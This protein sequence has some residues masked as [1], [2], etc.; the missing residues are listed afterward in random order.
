MGGQMGGWRGEWKEKELP[1]RTPGLSS[2][3]PLERE[4]EIHGL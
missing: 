4:S 1:H 2:A 3:Q